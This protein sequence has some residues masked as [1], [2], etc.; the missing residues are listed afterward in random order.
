MYVIFCTHQGQCIQ[1]RTCTQDGSLLILLFESAPPGESQTLSLVLL[2]L[3][4]LLLILLLFKP[5]PCHLL[6]FYVIC[7]FTSYYNGWIVCRVCH[8]L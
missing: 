1:N 4:K 3:I 6:S 7:H 5:D 8:P 2:L